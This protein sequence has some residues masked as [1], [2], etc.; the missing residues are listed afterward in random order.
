MNGKALAEVALRTWGLILVVTILFNI[1]F[2]LMFFNSMPGDF[3][4]I[5]L[6]ALG[7][8]LFGFFL[9]GW[10][11]KLARWWI[12]ETEVLSLE[13]SAKDLRTISFAIVGFLTEKK[14]DFV[15]FADWL[16]LDRYERDEGAEIGKAKQERSDISEIMAVIGAERSA[17][18]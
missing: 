11:G 18:K 17:A 3:G 2:L 9:M 16:A 4:L 8:L 13:V 14:I 6:N 15:S 12:P 10:G 5:G 1:P 7:Q